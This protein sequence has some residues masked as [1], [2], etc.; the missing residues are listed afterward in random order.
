MSFAALSE[1]FYFFGRE[2]L[3][4]IHVEEPAQGD[5][6]RA[7]D[8]NRIVCPECVA[9]VQGLC[10]READKS[11]NRPN[12]SDDVR[13]PLFRLVKGVQEPFT[14]SHARA[15]KQQFRAAY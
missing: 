7:D 5:A 13:E 15:A 9:K 14:N 1:Q 6:E 4:R 8:E 11:D 12:E 2:F 10:Y 3:F